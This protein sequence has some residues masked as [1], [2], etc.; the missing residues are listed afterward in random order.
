M[1]T[2]HHRIVFEYDQNIN[3]ISE[4]YQE[5]SS[6]NCI[7]LKRK[8]HIKIE[9]TNNDNDNILTFDLYILREEEFQHIQR[10]Y[11]YYTRIPTS[12]DDVFTNVSKF[13]ILND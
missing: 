4:K 6:T 8:N 9:F 10:T 13:D 11:Y 12:V 1:M 7:T 5:S 2:A 3:L